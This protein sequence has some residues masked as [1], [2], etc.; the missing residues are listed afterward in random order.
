MENFPQTVKAHLKRL[1]REAWFR[2]TRFKPDVDTS[3]QQ[4]RRTFKVEFRSENLLP[5]LRVHSI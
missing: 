4:Q 1:R 3:D 2:P 5:V